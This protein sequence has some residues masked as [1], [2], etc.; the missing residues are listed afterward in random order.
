VCVLR[1]CDEDLQARNHGVLM[2]SGACVANQ[3]QHP[4]RLTPNTTSWPVVHVIFLLPMHPCLRCRAATGASS[5]YPSVPPPAPS[6]PPAPTT[7]HRY[8]TDL[9]WPVPCMHQGHIGG[10]CLVRVAVRMGRLHPSPRPPP[11]C[12]HVTTSPRHP[13]AL[14]HP[15]HPRAHA[16]AHTLQCVTLLA[17][18]LPITQS[19]RILYRCHLL[20]AGRHLR[21]TRHV[22]HDPVRRVWRGARSWAQR[23]RA[24]PGRYHHQCGYHCVAIHRGATGRRC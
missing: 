21:F 19:S 2:G 7:P 14:P 22:R 8:R 18:V 15:R 20:F 23:L 9:V 17:S 13:I 1:Q 5:T 6:G 11:P 16:L 12:H 24:C 4:A 3:A 10:W